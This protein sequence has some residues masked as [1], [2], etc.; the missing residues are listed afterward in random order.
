MR[1]S[2]KVVVFGL[3]LVLALGT[4]LAA[5]AQP[6]PTAAPTAAPAVTVT[7][8]VPSQQEVYKLRAQHIGQPGG[9]LDFIAERYTELVETMSQGRLKMVWTG[10]G[11]IVP[12][13]ELLTAVGKGT[14]DMAET[15]SFYMMG[16]IPVANFAFGFP[17]Q[18]RSAEDCIR[19]QKMGFTDIVARAYAEHGAVEVIGA[20]VTDT[21]L[22]I[23][24]TKDAPRLADIEGMKIR[25]G[26]AL[27]TVLGKAGAS[28]VMMAG[29]ELYTAIS[30]GII[31]GA[32]YGD[33]AMAGA[34]G[35]L[36][37]TDYALTGLVGARHGG[38]FVINKE[39]WESLPA[40]LQEILNLVLKDWAYEGFYSVEDPELTTVTS[41]EMKIK[42][43]EQG[44][45]V[46][47]WPQEDM[48][49]ITELSIELMGE[50]AAKDKYCAEA[51]E[52]FK[53]M[54]KRR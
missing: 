54:L 4:I 1:K 42:F 36:E 24:L 41:Q 29:G 52:L 2:G 23:F 31:E 32:G 3:I 21:V 14:L 25:V 48:D 19:Y 22:P 49:K 37:A 18:F 39:K 33:W 7:V 46:I 44:G 6:S 35:I 34:I 17:G 20:M 40:D 50:L 43:A 11:T 9:T 16:S 38:E 53:E 10:S 26:G 27:G 45:K 5:C 12:D 8:T 30:T 47:T 51:L 13:M 15:I 28:I